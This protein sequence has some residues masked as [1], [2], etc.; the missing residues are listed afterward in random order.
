MGDLSMQR[1]EWYYWYRS[2]ST[3]LGRLQG[4]VG[5][6]LRRFGGGLKTAARRL[7]LA[8]IVVIWGRTILREVGSKLANGIHSANMGLNS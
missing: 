7:V 1:R 8:P 5:V 6:G 2:H 4:V 3:D